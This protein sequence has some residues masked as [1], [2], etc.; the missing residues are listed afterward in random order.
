[1]VTFLPRPSSSRP[2]TRQEVTAPSGMRLT[3]SSSWLQ[4]SSS[5][6]AT[7][8]LAPAMI[9]TS[10]PNMRPPRAALALATYTR[11]GD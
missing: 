3:S 6:L 7:I 5:S 1:M 4:A 10:Y 9:P 8:D 11:P 2:D